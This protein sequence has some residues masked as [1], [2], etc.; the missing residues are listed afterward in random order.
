MPGKQQ[1]INLIDDVRQGQGSSCQNHGN[2]W[3]TG[4]FQF[5][6]QFCLR[7]GQIDVRAAVCLAGEN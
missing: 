4:S 3:L 2:N 5:V 1:R 6:D 7:A